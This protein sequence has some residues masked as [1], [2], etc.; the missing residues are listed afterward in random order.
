MRY[1]GDPLSDVLFDDYGY[2]VVN[3]T[4][5]LSPE[6]AFPYQVFMEKHALRSKPTNCQYCRVKLEDGE[7]KACG[8]PND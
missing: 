7:C 8:G 5:T 2:P 1:L 3:S 6:Y 4:V